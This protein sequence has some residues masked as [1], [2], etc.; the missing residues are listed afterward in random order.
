MIGLVD[1]GL[2]NLRSVERALMHAGAQVRRVTGG[3]ELAEC[4][5]IVVPGQG[6]FRDCVAALKKNEL[7]DALR[8]W[9]EADKPY[10]GICLGMQVLFELSHENGEHQG[11]GLFRGEVIRFVG[12]PTQKVPQ[13]GWN[14]VHRTAVDSPLFRGIDDGSWFYF[15]HSYHV[16]TPDV[17]TV[18]GVTDYGI[19]FPS[20]TGR[21]RCQAVQFHP[22]KSQA[23]GLKLL[24]NFVESL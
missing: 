17:A 4:A 12:G 8:G 7:W 23:A 9:I 15:C 20:A 18:T 21:G 16:T 10:L 2:G 14:R 13:M 24:G 3:S 6:A 5:G 19:Q 11:L 22:E 1:Y